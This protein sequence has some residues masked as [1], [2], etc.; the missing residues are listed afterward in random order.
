MASR[1]LHIA[2]L[3]AAPS[4]KES[5]GVPGVARELLSG[6]SALGHRI[7]CFL[8]A[9]AGPEEPQELEARSNIRFIRGTSEWSYGRW[10]SSGRAGIFL[11][12]LATRAIGSLRLRREVL[13]RHRADPYD[14]VYQFSNIETLGM[15]AR[16]RGRVPLVIHPETHIAGELRFLWRERALALR[17]QPARSFALAAATMT[18]RSVV[19]RV[20]VRRASLLICISTVFR[21]HLHRDYGFPLERTLVVPNPI[22]LERFTEPRLGRALAEPPTVLVLGRVSARKGVEDV[23]AVARELLARGSDARVRVVGGATLWSDYRP[24]LED[25]P[26]ENAEFAGR[27]PPSEIASE[28]T[29]A[30]VM[31]A[32][33]KYEPFGLTVAEALACGVPIVATSEVGA[34]DGV[35]RSVVAETAPGDVMAMTDAIEGMIERLR[36][37]PRPLRENAREEAERL[38]ATATVCAQISAALQALVHGVQ[39]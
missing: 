27:I 20:R 8:P 39:S 19:Q 7:D 17:C 2:W 16:L 26:K 36:A 5:G 22:R 29:R 11:S 12:G 34:I 6:L 13:R 18:V 24:L 3:G 32:A 15:P 1:A 28:L 30:D 23:V 4:A 25:L 31:L 38:F 33:S 10:Y 37:E 14:V 21:D 35:S 9:A